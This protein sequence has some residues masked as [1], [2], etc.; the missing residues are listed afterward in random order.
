MPHS[1]IPCFKNMEKTETLKTIAVLSA[2]LIGAYLIFGASWLVWAALLLL[3]GGVFETRITTSLARY[4][5]KF[6]MVLGNVNSKIILAVIYF[7]V[8]TPVAFLFRIFN[9]PLVDHFRANKRSSYFDV[10]NKT[11]QKSD[12]EKMW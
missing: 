1:F 12:F 9:R 8:L 4:W 2:A 3:I 11:Y 6:A 5:L 10:L 7:A